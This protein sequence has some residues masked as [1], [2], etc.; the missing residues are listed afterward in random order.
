FELPSL[1]L[2]TPDLPP[3]TD[4]WRI[5][6]RPHGRMYAN[7]NETG[8]LLRELG[9]L[10]PLEVELDESAVPLL[11]QLRPHENELVWTIR[12][13][14]PA[15]EAAV[16]EIFDFVE[17]DCDLRIEPI[18]REAPATDELPPLPDLASPAPAGDDI[19]IAALLAAAQA[20]PA[21]TPVGAAPVAANEATPPPAPVPV[22]PPPTKATPAATPAAAAPAT[23]RVDLERVDRL[24]NVVGELVIQQAMLAQRVVESGLGRS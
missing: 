24:I 18:A 12:L 19:D 2:P 8:L 14:A 11:D 17:G 4:G 7:A 3:M 16:R 6:F 1:D 21:A 22:S 15:D 13:N 10:G 20:D 23:I 9:R 5:V